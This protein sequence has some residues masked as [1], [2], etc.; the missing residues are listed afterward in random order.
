VAVRL[1]FE[2]FLRPNRTLKLTVFYSHWIS[3]L[4]LKQ[5]INYVII[6]IEPTTIMAD[7]LSVAQP[8]QR[9]NSSQ[10]KNGKT[11][12]QQPNTGLLLTVPTPHASGNK[13]QQQAD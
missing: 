5:D 11:I 2:S 1:V 13:K 7:G 3:L 6:V 12:E 8:S 4:C 10:Q 9:P